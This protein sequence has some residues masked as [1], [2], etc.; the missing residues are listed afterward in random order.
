MKTTLLVALCIV[1]SM[2]LFSMEN[3]SN[4]YHSLDGSVYTEEQCKEIH[5]LFKESYN[6]QPD[7]IRSSMKSF[8]SKGIKLIYSV[9]NETGNTLLH[10][11]L[12][13]NNPE[14]AS[15]LLMYISRLF[16]SELILPHKNNQGKTVLQL[17]SEKKYTECI[18]YLK[19]L[20]KE[21]NRKAN[22]TQ[23]I[24]KQKH[25]I[26]IRKRLLSLF[27]I[28]VLGYLGLRMYKSTITKKELATS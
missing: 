27:T 9:S 13:N 8:R 7:K 20:E 6:L 11:L 17:A 12:E 4:S 21:L 10:L 16:Q 5:E 22:I 19:S 24:T 14:A 26:S 3:D 1:Q 28:S 15:A 25:T 18:R 23:S 2:S